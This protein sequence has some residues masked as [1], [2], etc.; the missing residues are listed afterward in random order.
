MNRIDIPMT[1]DISGGDVPLSVSDG[2][3][4]TLGMDT[5]IYA[6]PAERYAGP[7]HVTPGPD[8]QVLDTAGKMA[9]EDI[10]IGAIPS[11]YGLIEWNGSALR[12]S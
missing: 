2:Q 3:S 6:G 5:A 10:T 9:D 8:P 7:Y 12:I 1:V 4:V 11:N